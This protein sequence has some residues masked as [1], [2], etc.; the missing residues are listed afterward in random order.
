MLVTGDGPRR[1]LARGEH[2]WHYRAPRGISFCVL[3]LSLIFA[4]IFRRVFTIFIL[5][6]RFFFPVCMCFG[7]E[8]S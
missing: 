8:E 1:I 4:F 2:A 5:L 7:C 3:A 6:D